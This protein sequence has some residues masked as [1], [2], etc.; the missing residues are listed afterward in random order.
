MPPSKRCRLFLTTHTTGPSH[1][2][3]VKSRLWLSLKA[4]LPHRPWSRSKQRSHK[5]H[6]PAEDTRAKIKCATSF[7]LTKFSATQLSL[8]LLYKCAKFPIEVWTPFPLLQSS[9]TLLLESLRRKVNT[10]SGNKNKVKE[11]SNTFKAE[12]SFLFDN[13]TDIIS[14]LNFLIVDTRNQW[15]A[16]TCKLKEKGNQKR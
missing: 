4:W 3:S 7:V 10:K 16:S 1:G 6:G 9:S 15:M 14:S 11:T 5:H 8:G 13:R 12:F 2:W